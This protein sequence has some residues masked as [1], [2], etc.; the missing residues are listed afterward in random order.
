MDMLQFYQSILT[1]AGMVVNKD[2]TVSIVDHEEGKN[3]PMT[4]KG[5]RLVIPTKEQIGERT[6]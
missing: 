1:L 6:K 3:T 5:R 2:G 4:I